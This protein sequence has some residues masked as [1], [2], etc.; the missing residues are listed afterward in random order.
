MK[1]AI[2][3]DYQN[4]ALEMADWTA[5]T[6]RAEITV[7]N[8]HLVDVEALIERLAP[9]DII[10]VMRERT[11]LPREVLQRL[12]RL[13]LIASTGPRNTSIDMTAAKELGIEVTGTG[14]EST[15]T[16]EH[17]WALILASARSIVRENEA[18]RD[19]LWQTSIGEELRSKTLGILG[20]GNIGREVAR[21]G[22]AFGM[23]VIAWSEHL[24][25]ENAEAAGAK[26]VSKEELFRQADILTVHL[27][28]SPRTKGLVGANELGLM[29]PTARLVN[30]SRG[31]IVDE[32]ALIKAI[33]SLA[34][35][36]AGI[37]VFGVEPLP[38]EH[39]FRGMTNILATPHIG[40]VTDSLYRTFFGDV[41]KSITAWLD[42]Q[43]AV[44]RQVKT[45]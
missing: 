25:Q 38:P 43:A 23:K 9:F 13:R 11:P 31:P 5:L 32:A 44:A 10:C 28:L 20:L 12:P 17:T 41:V 21:I 30:T 4:V 22:R 33:R 14:Y 1:I 18:L 2:L 6:S 37:D 26:L 40:Y 36:G 7:F 15:P 19:G 35:A 8:D 29:K 3:D 34:I 45:T 27:V 42:R 24:T 39:P 16:I